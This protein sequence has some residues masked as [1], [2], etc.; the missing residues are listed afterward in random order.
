VS[1]RRADYA[2]H[3]SLPGGMRV[4]LRPVRDEDLAHAGEYFAGLSPESRYMRFMCSTPEL[5]PQTL[6]LLKHQ[7]HEGSAAVIAALVNHSGGDEIV[8]GVRIVPG[9]KPHHCEFALTVVD[10][11][12]GRG[13]GRVLLT[14]G[15]RAAREL[16]YRRIEGVVL[17]ANA[18]MLGLAQHLRMHVE[19]A[20]PGVMHV[21]R[22][23]VPLRGRR[24]QALP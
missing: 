5:T 10:R 6:E 17:A 20:S 22:D 24:A 18:K 21:Y 14:E 15:I 12:Q 13:V 1:A 16:G 4:Y 23:L 8:G 7:L 11:W 19:R 9:T 2:R 3:A